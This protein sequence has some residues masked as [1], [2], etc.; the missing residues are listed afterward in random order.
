MQ[1]I[2][3]LKPD[4]GGGAVQWSAVRF[5]CVA[6]PREQRA[7]RSRKG[8]K[9]GELKAWSCCEKRRAPQ[10]ATG[11]HTTQIPSNLVPAEKVACLSPENKLS[12]YYY[13]A[14]HINQS[15]QPSQSAS[16]FQ[17]NTTKCLADFWNGLLRIGSRVRRHR[18]QTVQSM[19]SRVAQI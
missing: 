8:R 14:R 2:I 16:V 5:G 15:F 12:G 6:H 7:G 9:I 13:I 1:T 19:D 18:Q 17:G 11:T 10:L 4:L 3:S